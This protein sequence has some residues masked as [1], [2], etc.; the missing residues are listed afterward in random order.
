M[1]L[2]I[3][4]L[5]TWTLPLWGLFLLVFFLGGVLTVPVT[6]RSRIPL[7]SAAS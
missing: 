3:G 7:K 5:W 2:D 1:E 6:Y 4:S